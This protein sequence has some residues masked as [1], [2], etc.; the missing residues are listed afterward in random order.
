MAIGAAVG[1]RIADRVRSPLRI[2]GILEC[3]L[4][5][6]VLVTPISFRLIHEV[7]RGIYPTL[8]GSPGAARDVVRLVLAVLALA[9]ATIL[10]GATFP[11]LTR[12]LTRTNALS[13]AFGRLMRRTPSGPSSGRWPPAWSL[14]SSS[15]CPA[16]WRSARAAPPSPAS[17]PSGSR[18]GGR[19]EDGR[20][21]RLR[22][23]RPRRTPVSADAPG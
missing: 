13:R 10:M 12:Y 23:P 18:R 6:V 16:R 22:R 11:S 1:G 15:G 5:V 4:V 2:Y 3:V 7:Y 14:S 17:P 9:P 8:E 19:G 20:A 21:R